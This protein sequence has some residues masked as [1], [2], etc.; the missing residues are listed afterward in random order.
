MDLTLFLVYDLRMGGLQRVVTLIANTLDVKGVSTE[1]VSIENSK[2]YY[3]SSVPT[4]SLLE[5]RRKTSLIL[6]KILRACIYFLFK[7]T[8]SFEFVNKII[9]NKLEKKI[10]EKNYKTIVASGDT[11]LY[12]PILKRKFPNI[13]FIA[14]E[15]NNADIYMNRYFKRDLELFKKSL[16]VA[17]QVICLTNYDQ[18][19]FKEFSKNVKC[20]YNPLT[21]DNT[22]VSSLT[23]H[24]IS[25]VGRIDME[26]KGIDFL[27]QVA[28][29][30]PNGIKITVAGDGNKKNMREFRKKISRYNAEDKIIYKGALKD[31][32]LISHFL[33]SSIY[34]MTSRWEGFGLVLVEAMSFGLPIISFN[35]SGSQEVLEGGKNGVLVENGNV[36]AIVKE[37]EK[38]VANIELRKNYQKKSLERVKDFSIEKIIEQW[39]ELL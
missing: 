3:D 24:N 32:A 11:S 28:S 19:K 15:H 8:I 4:S 5:N 13:K 26:H 36:I 14:W 9:I 22:K 17:D 16:E 38:F 23:S 35:Q 7:K 39:R 33:D 29:K 25:F 2:W 20:I 18:K 31:E 37:V 10:Q 30:L 1:I 34:L 6:K 12:I 21:I 27:V